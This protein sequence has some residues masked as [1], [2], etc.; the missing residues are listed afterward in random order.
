MYGIQQGVWLLILTGTEDGSSVHCPVY[1]CLPLQPPPAQLTECH[2]LERTPTA[3]NKAK[4]QRR[5][6]VLSLSVKLVCVWIGVF[7]NWHTKNTLPVCFLEYQHTVHSDNRVFKYFLWKWCKNVICFIQ[8]QSYINFKKC[9]AKIKATIQKYYSWNQK[10]EVSKCLQR[11]V[12]I[13][14][15]I[16]ILLGIKVLCNFYCKIFGWVFS[17]WSYYMPMW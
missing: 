7:K 14:F 6:V 12:N 4:P 8:I 17:C 15:N 11:S 2:F 13:H 9:A 16:L 5:C 1:Y 10:W 3:G